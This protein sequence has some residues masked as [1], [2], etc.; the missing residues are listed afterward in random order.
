MSNVRVANFSFT[1]LSYLINNITQYSVRQYLYKY[2][3]IRIS[4]VYKYCTDNCLSMIKN[5]ITN[6]NRALQYNVLIDYMRIHQYI[7][8]VKTRNHIIRGPN[9]NHLK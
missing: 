5:K 7:E 3:T 9:M 8:H 4:N 1:I 6:T 2:T